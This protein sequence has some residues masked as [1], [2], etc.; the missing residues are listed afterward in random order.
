M[1]S[2]RH[3]FK[4]KTTISLRNSVN[5]HKWGK[6]GSFELSMSYKSHCYMVRLLIRMLIYHEASMSLFSSTLGEHSMIIRTYLFTLASV[7]YTHV[8]SKFTNSNI[9]FRQMCKS[10]GLK[11]YLLCVCYCPTQLK[12]RNKQISI[13]I[14]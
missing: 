6:E 2:Y 3:V 14:I 13:L 8:V 11:K 10:G 1:R 5:I 12:N 4:N 7:S 9:L